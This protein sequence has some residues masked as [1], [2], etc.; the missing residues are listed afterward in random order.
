MLLDVIRT[1]RAELDLDPWGDHAEAYF[2]W[3]LEK[4][5][6]DRAE[7]DRSKELEDLNEK[8]RSANELARQRMK[9]LQE[10]ERELE[11]LTRA[12]QKAGEAPSDQR[13][14]KREEPV[15]SDEAGREIIERLR[16]QVEG[17]KADI[18][19]RQQ[20]HR[21]LRRQLQEERARLAEADECT[22]VQTGGIGPFRGGCRH[23]PRIRT[24]P[25]ENSRSRIRPRIPEG[26]RAHA[27]PCR[28]KSPPLPGQ[29]CGSR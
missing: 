9:E 18:R 15:V 28:R 20:D 24:V 16:N 3:T 10:K 29:F 25:Q 2:D 26:M 5:E 21:A 12:F 22:L 6:E 27:F 7:Q 17:L 14:Q 19:Q 11:S 13:P 8:L 23:P 4:M 1:G